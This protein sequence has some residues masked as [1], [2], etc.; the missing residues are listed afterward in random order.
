GSCYGCHIPL[1]LHLGNL[2]RKPKAR[3]EEVEPFDHGISC[4]T[5]H[6]GPDG[7]ILGPFGAATDAHVSTKSDL[8]ES[9]GVDRL[10]SSCHRTN[11]GPVIGVAKDFDST[12]QAE[13]GRSCVGCHMS[14]SY[15]KIAEYDSKEPLFERKGR[16]HRINGPSDPEFLERAFQFSI[17]HA[18]DR[19]TLSIANGAGHRVPALVGRS[20]ELTAVLFDAADKEIERQEIKFDHYSFLDVSQPYQLKFKRQ[21]VAVLVTAQHFARIG[22]KP[23]DFINERVTE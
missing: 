20:F 11:I 19:T 1:P 14:V 23:V 16:S 15:R 2:D 7:T 17:S 6:E 10:C 22:A 18:K 9:P 21:G 13:K 4:K 12:E 8:F 3:T 5:C